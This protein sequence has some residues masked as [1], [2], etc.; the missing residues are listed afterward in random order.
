MTSP[1][2]DSM[3]PTS[4]SPIS[5]VSVMLP[6]V[7]R[8]ICWTSMPMPSSSPSERRVDAARASR[9]D[10]EVDDRR[11]GGQRVGERARVARVAVVEA[12]G[13]EVER[14]AVVARRDVADLDVVARA[15]VAV[16][17]AGVAE[18]LGRGDLRALGRS[19]T[20]AGSCRSRPAEHPAGSGPGRRSAGSGWRLPAGGAA[21]A[22]GRVVQ[23]DGQAV[24]RRQRRRPGCVSLTTTSMSL[25]ATR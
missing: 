2:V 8:K 22:V 21:D 11:R 9:E 20:P 1:A 4:R 23:R 15:H 12:R 14:R 7:N 3:C 10:H 24:E 6:L 19:R 16:G 18:R 25:P 5:S 17:R 13:R